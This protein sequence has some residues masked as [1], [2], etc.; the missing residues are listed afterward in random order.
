M[1]QLKGSIPLDFSEFEVLKRPDTRITEMLVRVKEDGR[2]AINDVL[3]KQIKNLKLRLLISPDRRTLVL[4][5]NGEANYPFPK[6]GVVTDPELAQ[7]VANR[8]ISL[9]AKYVV[10]WHGASR[11]WVGQLKEEP[12]V[13]DPARLA[14]KYKKPVGKHRVEA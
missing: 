10:S 11:V 2:I 5:E 7:S 8:G 3:L 6:S 12:Q 14:Q 4:D 9:P 1:G 13:P